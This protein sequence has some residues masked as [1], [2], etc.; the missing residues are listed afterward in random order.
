MADEN[1]DAD[2]PR[3]H[4]TFDH[5]RQDSVST[6]AKVRGKVKRGTGTRDQ[7]EIVIEGRG[8]SAEEAAADFEAA[9]EAAEAG[10]WADRLRALQPDEGDDE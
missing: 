9:L 1:T 8:A 6:G 10:E 4:R 7:D 2:D 3:E 5:G